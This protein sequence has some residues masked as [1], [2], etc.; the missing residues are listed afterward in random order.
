[1][2]MLVRKPGGRARAM[3]GGLKRAR[4]RRLLYAVALAAAD[5]VLYALGAPRP[6]AVGFLVLALLM[7]LAGVMVDPDRWDR[8][9][10]GESATA[11]ELDRLSRRQWAVWH[12]L[13]VPGSRANVDHLVVGRTGVWVID[14]KTT[15]ARVHARWWGVRFGDRPLDTAPVRWE[16]EVVSDR[17][18]GR[19]GHDLPVRTLVA[20]HGAG[21]RRRGGRSGGVK[22]VPAGRLTDRIRRGPRRLGRA[23]RAQVTAAV[24]AIFGPEFG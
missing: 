11:L 22:V 23:E 16:A 18:A 24:E 9:A 21:M 7:G 14:T 3:A 17:L 12:D 15:R 5:V 1:M 19:L 4:R 20:V 13:R 2:A 6:V 10:A 8:G